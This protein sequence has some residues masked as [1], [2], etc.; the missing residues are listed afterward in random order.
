MCQKPKGRQLP[1]PP[2]GGGQQQG[3][4]A[5]QEQRVA[6]ASPCTDLPAPAVPSA[7]L[8]PVPVASSQNSNTLPARARASQNN[9]F[10]AQEYHHAFK[11]TQLLSCMISVKSRVITAERVLVLGT[12]TAQVQKI[13]PGGPTVHTAPPA[14]V[15]GAMPDLPQGTAPG[16]GRDPPPSRRLSETAE[17]II[18][19]FSSHPQPA[20]FPACQRMGCTSNRHI[21]NTASQ[22]P[23]YVQIRH[24]LATD[25][26]FMFC[27][28][29]QGATP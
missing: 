13:F 11:G 7:C 4:Q 2:A 27:P 22:K 21:L 19:P 3:Q 18:L 6:A 24:F 20:L 16:A 8:G 15:P 1:P 23:H 25:K 5:G 17:S 10:C 9:L 29:H 28:R 26:V 14:A 12:L